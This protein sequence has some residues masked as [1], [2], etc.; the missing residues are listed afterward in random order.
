MPAQILRLLHGI[1]PFL[2]AL[3]AVWLGGNFLYV[4]WRRKRQGFVFPTHGVLFAERFIVG[5][6]QRAIT[7][8]LGN[9]GCPIN[10]ALTAEELWI[11]QFPF[12]TFAAFFDLDHRIARTAITKIELAGE[13]TLLTYRSGGGIESKMELHLRNPARFLEALEYLPQSRA[14]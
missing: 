11:V 8:K 3:V 12:S 14:T 1:S 4:Q 7:G 5:R 13:K 2:Y 10:V 9:G 6:S